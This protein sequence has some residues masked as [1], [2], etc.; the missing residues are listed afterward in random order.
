MCVCV[1]HALSCLTVQ[2]TRNLTFGP[3]CVL[4]VC[5]FAIVCVCVCV[6]VCVS[7]CV[8]VCARARLCVCLALL[9]TALP[10]TQNVLRYIL[11]GKIF[12]PNIPPIFDPTPVLR[13]LF[14]EGPDIS[15]PF[16]HSH[17]D[18]PQSVAMSSIG[19]E[20]VNILSSLAAQTFGA[21]D[22]GQIWYKETL[23]AQLS[24][25]NGLCSQPCRQCKQC[26]T[27][28]HIRVVAKA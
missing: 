3:G 28:Q 10:R 26:G 11:R 27:T 22:I 13:L 6:C 14:H 2:L 12:V 24:V 5:L 20:D 19:H 15:A 21:N 25:K 1:E 7:V 16:P 17:S 18:A 23:L 8:C 4:L 9:S